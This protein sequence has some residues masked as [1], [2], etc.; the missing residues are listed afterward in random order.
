M[1]SNSKAEDISPPYEDAIENSQNDT[2][3]P[4][5]FILAG[6]SIQN[7][8]N[9]ST[10]LFDISGD[11]TSTSHRGT[12]IK[13][14]RVEHDQPE[15]PESKVSKNQ[16]LFYLAHPA[17]AQYRT[18]IPAYYLT[19][20]SP[21]TLGNIR[22]ETSKSRL[23]KVGFKALLSAR[24]TA[25]DKPLFDEKI[26]QLLFSAK[27]KWT[28]GRYRWADVDGREIAV[29]D[30]KGEQHKLVV[31]APIQKDMRDALVALWVLRLWYDTAESRQAKRD[32]LESLTSP[33][34]YTGM[35]LK[36][37][38]R[39]GALGAIGGGGA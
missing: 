4:T 6:Q 39:A 10:S 28:G 25:S 33:S 35:D 38:K 36:F 27:A 30:R 3:E 13:F 11:I 37:A 14:E 21:K 20:A 17:H 18:D 26:E 5:V 32:A 16:H 31:T 19:S 34:A 9:P 29:E 7:E 15:K 12:S 23:Q 8:S 2:L 24:K 1:D 22:F